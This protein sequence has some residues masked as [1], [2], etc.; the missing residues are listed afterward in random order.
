[1]DN[2]AANQTGNYQN[3]ILKWYR[4]GESRGMIL[5]KAANRYANLWAEVKVI[6]D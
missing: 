1:M 5:V 4:N 2:R 3:W 6:Q